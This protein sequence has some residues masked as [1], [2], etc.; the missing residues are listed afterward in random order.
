MQVCVH[1]SV[2][3][4]TGLFLADLSANSFLILGMAE[5]GLLP[6]IFAKR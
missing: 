5:T 2:F 3:S 6:A 1:T 4:V